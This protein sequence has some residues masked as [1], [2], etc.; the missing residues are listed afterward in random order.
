MTTN[1][2]RELMDRIKASPLGGRIGW[3]PEVDGVPVAVPLDRGAPGARLGLEA[4]RDWCRETWPDG[5]DRV[6]RGAD[7]EAVIVA[8]DDTGAVYAKMRWG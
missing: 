2:Q 1:K 7:D 4:I 5:A 6:R 8:P 3:P